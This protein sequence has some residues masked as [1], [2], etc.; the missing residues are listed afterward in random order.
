[1]HTARVRRTTWRARRFHTLLGQAHIVA[2]ANNVLLRLHNLYPDFRHEH[3][4][5]NGDSGGSSKDLLNQGGRDGGEKFSWR[6]HLVNKQGDWLSGQWA[7]GD[8][9]TSMRGWI[10]QK[11]KTSKDE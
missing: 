4:V 10:C 2:V 5:E 3:D 6:C 9:I 11:S 1:M 7:R 8:A